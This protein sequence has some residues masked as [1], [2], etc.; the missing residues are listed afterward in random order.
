MQV[1]LYL[2]TTIDETQRTSSII[3]NITKVEMSIAAINFN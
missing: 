3:Y 1:R 2:I